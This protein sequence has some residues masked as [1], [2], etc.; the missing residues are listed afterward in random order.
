MD[1]LCRQ[2]FAEFGCDCGMGFEVLLSI[3]FI[4]FDLQVDVLPY[5]PGSPFDL[6]CLWTP[7]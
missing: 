1:A 4:G 5:G 6:A 2:P 7:A 3:R